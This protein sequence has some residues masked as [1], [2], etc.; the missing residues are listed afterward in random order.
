M[1]G[2]FKQ[3]FTT[4]IERRSYSGIYATLS[5]LLFLGTFWAVY[6]EVDSRRPWKDYQEEYKTLRVRVLKYRL[7]QARQGVSK[8]DLSKTDHSIKQIDAKL[9]SGKLKEVS[10]EV[11][12]IAIRIRDVSQD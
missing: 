7:K 6:N 5:L 3:R 1:A 9:S 2:W 10:D 8:D 12:R 4:P 11:D